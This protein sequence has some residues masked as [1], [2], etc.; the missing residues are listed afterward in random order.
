MNMRELPNFE[1]P[2]EKLEFYGEEKLS[3][4]ELLAIIIRTGNKNET[5]VQ[6]SQKVINLGKT[7]TCKDLRFIQSITLPELMS[8]NGIGKVKAIQIKAVGELAKRITKPLLKKE[9]SLKGTD[10]VANLLLPEMQWEKREL[11]KVLILNYKNIL[12][13]IKDISY[14]GTNYA[15]LHPKEVLIDAVK[16]QADRIILVHNHP[17]GDPTPSEND[18]EVTKRILEASNILGIDF[19][20]HIVIGAGKYESVFSLLKRKD[21]KDV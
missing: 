5:S 20:D 6:L 15:M 7:Q 13:T 11:V 10:D 8:I 3:S 19:I 16:M 21:R 4:A 12:L 18:Y 14:G 1:R 17:S 9:I 2:Y